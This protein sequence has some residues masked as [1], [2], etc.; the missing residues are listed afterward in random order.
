MVRA[1][2][3]RA[4]LSSLRVIGP[5]R[6]GRGPA[7]LQE[8]GAGVP[9]A[10]FQPLGDVERRAFAPAAEGRGGEQRVQRCGER[11]AFTEL[12]DP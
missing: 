7:R 6:E 4:R 9:C 5:S 12:D 1:W 3:I 11:L 2:P 10:R 8:R